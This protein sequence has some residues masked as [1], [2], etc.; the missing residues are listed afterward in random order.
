M[1][2][3]KRAADFLEE[4]GYLVVDGAKSIYTKFPELSE[5]SGATSSIMKVSFPKIEKAL[6]NRAEFNHKINYLQLPTGEH[7]IYCV[8]LGQRGLNIVKDKAIKWIK[9]QGIK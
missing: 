5:A 1:T 3:E 4:N 8:S 2:D 9:D 6:K 7:V